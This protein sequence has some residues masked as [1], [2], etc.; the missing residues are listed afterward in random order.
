MRDAVQ[1][2]ALV[3]RR[4]PLAHAAD[5]WACARMEGEGQAAA[6][7]FPEPTH[8]HAGQS[9]AVQTCIIYNI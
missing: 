9:A 3:L 1:R 6:L 5:A 4:D 8:Q 7:V 2:P